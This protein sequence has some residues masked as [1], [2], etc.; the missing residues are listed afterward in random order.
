MTWAF[1][2]PGIRSARTVL[3]LAAIVSAYSGGMSVFA[4]NIVDGRWTAHV[5]EMPLGRAV[6]YWIAGFVAA[7][8]AQA[9][10]SVPR[11]R[12]IAAAPAG[13]RLRHTVLFLLALPPLAGAFAYQG[14]QTFTALGLVCWLGGLALL[15]NALL[16]D[17]A[18]P[19]ARGLRALVSF[20]RR[21]PRTALALVAILVL[22]A[23]V[24]FVQ[25]WAIPVDM[26]ADH[27]EK[28]LSVQSVLDGRFEIFFASN[29][30]RESLHMFVTALLSP[31]TGG[32]TFETLKLS[33]ALESMVGVAALYGLGAALAGGGSRRARALGLTAALVAAVGVWHILITRASLR[34]MLTPLVATG[35]L[36][37]L[38]RL[39]RY[40]R[41]QDA[42]VAGLLIGLGFY[43]YQSL[44]IAP[45]LAI[46][47]AT[48]SLASARSAGER[49]RAVA[50]LVVTGIV[51]LAVCLPVLRYMAENPASFWS[52]M[53][54]TVLD[55]RHGCESAAVPCR[56][57]VDVLKSFPG[58]FAATA[59]MLVYRGDRN[60]AYNAPTYPSL[61]PLAGGLLVSAL[62]A[63]L[64]L[65]LRGD[66][67]PAF[68][69]AAIVVLMI[70]G[71]ITVAR[72][73]EVPSSARTAGAMPVVY[74]AVAYALTEA[75]RL[76]SS[77]VP[78]RWRTAAAALPVLCCALPM[79]WHS[80]AVVSMPY[81]ASSVQGAVS[82]RDLGVSLAAFAAET[83]TW[84]NTFLIHRPHYLDVR[85][86][87]LHAGL[88]LS[89]PP[90]VESAI[91]DL[92]RRM[93][94]NAGAIGPQRLDPSRDLLFVFSYRDE[95]TLWTLV[96]WFPDGT[97]S[98]LWTRLG[99]PYQ[100]EEPIVLFRVPALGV[101]GLTAFLDAR[102]APAGH[103]DE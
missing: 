39:I 26:N 28:V 100:A 54:S 41:R 48:I 6:P 90:T 37:A 61:D 25:L 35:I 87:L 34:L 50:N 20:P 86:V 7:F 47:A 22:A 13:Y 89:G 8:A 97:P 83:R 78:R 23:V 40:N 43:S 103:A 82:A 1:W 33:A 69:L 93:A 51:T 12:T 18:A 14:P 30:G 73:D 42:V 5:I 67:I 57:P 49:S 55:S 24:R 52:R 94:I 19:L 85:A 80:W 72:P 74:V 88:S 16:P 71:A 21:R 91:D 29:G 27:I 56:T 95:L 65:V 102:Y 2:F 99:T 96:Q 59:L 64:A 9:L 17:G 98:P 32:L 58:N 10:G 44:R 15:Y 53:S 75:T 77:F 101:D 4:P 76:I 3:W 63:G 36:W 46:A 31:L 66:R 62:G 60:A 38:V 84:G 68:L 92:P 45:A 81:A 70:P 79:A 11:R